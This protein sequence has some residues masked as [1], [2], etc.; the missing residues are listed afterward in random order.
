M[1]ASLC[2]QFGLVFL[3][4]WRKRT[5]RNPLIVLLWCFYQ[6]ADYIAILA[7]GNILKKQNEQ[8][9]GDLTTF[10]APFILLHLG[11]PDTITSYSIEDNELWLRHL[12]G[13]AVQTTIAFIVVLGLLAIPRLRLAVTK[14]N[15]EEIG[16]ASCRERVSF[17]V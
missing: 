8:G 14:S 11:G 7:L 2:L 3:S 6:T 4:P 12:I 10:W 1:L 13:L 16:R 9:S 5:A 17:I 15:Q